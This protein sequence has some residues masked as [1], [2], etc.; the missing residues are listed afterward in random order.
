MWRC[1]GARICIFP[2]GFRHV[3][4]PGITAFVFFSTALCYESMKKPGTVWSFQKKK[5]KE[6][7]QLKRRS[8]APRATFYFYSQPETVHFSLSIVPETIHFTWLQLETNSSLRVAS[9]QED[10]N[11]TQR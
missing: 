5:K 11:A 3:E 4:V 6:E 9:V 8:S 1:P 7:N 10:T 2:S